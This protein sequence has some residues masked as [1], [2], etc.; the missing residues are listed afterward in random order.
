MR[1]T[2]RLKSEARSASE[3]SFLRKTEPT[4]VCYV[5][6]CGKWP[7]PHSSNDRATSTRT[8]VANDFPMLNWFFP[9]LNW[10]AHISELWHQHKLLPRR[11]RRR[12]PRRPGHGE[13]LGT[14]YKCDSTTTG[15]SK[16]KRSPWPAEIP[17]RYPPKTV[18]H[19]YFCFCHCHS[20]LSLSA[21]KKQWSIVL[22]LW[23]NSKQGERHHRL[24]VCGDWHHKNNNCDERNKTRFVCVS[25]HF[26][27]APPNSCHCCN[28]TPLTGAL[29]CS[30]IERPTLS[31]YLRFALACRMRNATSRDSLLRC[32]W[33]LCH[34]YGRTTPR[35][36]LGP[37]RP[38]RTICGSTPWANR[39]QHHSIPREGGGEGGGG[40]RGGRYGRAFLPF[41]Y[42]WLMAIH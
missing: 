24:F 42:I 26:R 23:G 31:T 39:S 25:S 3:S 15:L 1:M 22:R 4:V 41:P 10:K 6:C 5:F 12:R 28:R 38:M 17:T 16:A 29:A 27:S 32:S 9:L 35:S 40:E 34:R 14:I 30:V 2:L 33:S 21:A 13:R 18:F 19:W 7:G 37:R 36:C 8:L 20:R 11:P